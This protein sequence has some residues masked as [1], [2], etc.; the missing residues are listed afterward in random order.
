MILS[1]RTLETL[2]PL[3]PFVTR[4]VQNGKSYGLSVAGYDIRIAEAHKIEPRVFTLGSSLERFMMPTNVLGMVKD[5][6]SWARDGLQVFNTVIEPGWE[7][8]LTIELFNTGYKTLVL[9]PGDPI[10]QVIFEYTDWDTDGYDGK[11]QDQEA[12]PQVARYER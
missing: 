10:A 9:E 7:G 11:Y 1:A 12:G 4:A 5:K 2:R 6:S 8:Y 3:E